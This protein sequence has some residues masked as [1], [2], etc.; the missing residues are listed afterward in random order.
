VVLN[1]ETKYPNRRAYVLKLCS[2]A[3]PD[4]LTGRI[5]NFLTG[6]QCEF[7]NE[8]ELLEFLEL[9]LAGSASDAAPGATGR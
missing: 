8:R 7:A 1:A 4:A 2:D 3:V 9:E 5:E 6:Q